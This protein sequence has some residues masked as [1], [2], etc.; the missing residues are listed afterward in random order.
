MLVANPSATGWTTQDLIDN[1]L[2]VFAAKDP[3]FATLLIGVNDWVQGVDTKTFQGNLEIILDAMQ[4]ELPNK[5]AIVLVTIPDF[6]V[7]PQ[8]K[9]FTNGRDPVAGIQEFN[10]I[11]KEEGRKRNLQVVDIFPLSQAMGTDASLV[12]SD[13]LHPSAKEY[14]LWEKQIFPVV[15]K[16]LRK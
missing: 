1:E 13:G 7:T 8:G 12:A 6:S 14:M 4:T 15:F 11:I 9:N 10:A 16:K 3:T 2:P 5:H